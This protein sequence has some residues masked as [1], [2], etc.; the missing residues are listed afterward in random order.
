MLTNLNSLVVTLMASASIAK[1]CSV[2]SAYLSLP[3]DQ[4]AL[5]IPSGES[6]EHIALGFGVQN[7]TCSSAGT[8]AYVPEIL[9]AARMFYTRHPI[10]SVGAVAELLDISCLYGTKVFPALTASAFNV[11]N[12]SKHITAQGVIAALGDS[13]AV[14][15]Q[16]YFVTNPF[17]G[18]G[19]SPTFDFRAASQAGDPDAYIIANKTGDVPAPTGSQDV[20]W[21]ELA[22][23]V[24]GLAKHVFRVDTK[25][26]QPPASV[27]S[28]AFSN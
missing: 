14:L 7:Y 27:S 24:G 5:V 15:G 26:G 28:A 11:F 21:L 22:G 18:V 20:D 25:W 23:A 19:V 8:Y 9:A 4:T 12:A 6:V 10:R 16:H 13:A 2:Q 3:R 17:T 1:S